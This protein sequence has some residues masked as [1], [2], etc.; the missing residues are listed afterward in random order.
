MV[1]I[2]SDWQLFVT[3]AVI[4]AGTV[5]TR[6]LPFLIFRGAGKIPESLQRL[7]VLLP[8]AVIGLLVV[9]CLKGVS[10]FSGGRGLPELIALAALAA[11]PVWTKYALLSIATGT[12]AYMLLVQLV[13]V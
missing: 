13:F 3:I 2:L 10:V 1:N 5:I 9:Y 6:V 12:A 8:S 4:A 11:V 7:Q